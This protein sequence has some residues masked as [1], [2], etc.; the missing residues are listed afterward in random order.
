MSGE[1]QAL[2][3]SPR[4]G[5]AHRTDEADP[6]TVLGDRLRV[7]ETGDPPAGPL[8]PLQ[9]PHLSRKPAVPFASESA[10]R[11]HRADAGAREQPHHH[12]YPVGQISH[13]PV[14][15]RDTQ[16]AQSGRH[17]RDVA[18]QLLPRDLDRVAPFVDSHDRDCRIVSA[19]EDLRG[20]VEPRSGEP[21]RAGHARVR[22]RGCAGWA[23]RES[24]VVPYKSPEPL[25]VAGRLLP[26]ARVIVGQRDPGAFARRMG[27]FG[28]SCGFDVLGRRCPVGLFLRHGVALSLLNRPQHGRICPTSSSWRRSPATPPSTSS[29]TP[30]PRP[31]PARRSTGCTPSPAS[32]ASMP[33]RPSA[34]CA[35]A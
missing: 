25:G 1:V 13:D 22:E 18:A 20:I 7:L 12:F 19:I 17:R 4:G 24:E 5:I 3:G 2:S 27:E 6:E 29:S 14:A 15:D 31:L 23:L 9:H 35:G 10:H 33:C 28:N 8:G 30:R 16:L 32:A 26:Q 34:P 21:D 11:P